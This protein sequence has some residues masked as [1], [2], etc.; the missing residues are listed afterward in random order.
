MFKSKTWQAWKN[1]LSN[2]W[3]SPM[4]FVLL[5]TEKPE[6]QV[7]HEWSFLPKNVLIFPLISHFFFQNSTR[8]YRNWVDSFLNLA[9]L[10][11]FVCVKIIIYI[12]N[13]ANQ[14]AGCNAPT[15]RTL[16]YS[17]STRPNGSR[18]KI[19]CFVPVGIFCY[20]KSIFNIFE[21][22]T[23]LCTSI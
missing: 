3:P 4:I 19:F 21:P 23:H 14:T 17:R 16:N 11:S 13:F 15:T 7:K 10:F 22:K 2:V 9:E 12:K 5:A 1:D 18:K 20:R 6:A 8:E